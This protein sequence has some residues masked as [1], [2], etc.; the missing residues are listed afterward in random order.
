MVTTVVDSGE[1]LRRQNRVLVDLARRQSV[2]V[3]LDAALRDVAVAAA[4]TLDV[5]RV[6]IWFFTDDRAVIRCAEVYE[7]GEAHHARGAEL[8]VSAYPAY[9]HAIETERS[10]AAHDAMTD[11]RTAALADDYLR[12]LGITS[13][14]DSPVRRARVHHQPYPIQRADV[15]D[16]EETMIWAA[17]IRRPESAP[18][19]HYASEV[20]VKVYPLERL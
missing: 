17:G 13:M 14:L 16:F 6:S 8:L 3:D 1:R 10:V 11:P 15:L 5:D 9:V 2:H 19:R 20:G 4:E 12:P 7:R 18:L